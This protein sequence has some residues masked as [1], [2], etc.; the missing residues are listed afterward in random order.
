MEDNMSKYTPIRWGMMISAIVIAWQSLLIP[1]HANDARS[2]EVRLRT[3]NPTVEVAY[4]D[5]TG[6]ASFVFAPEGIDLVD[7]RRAN[8]TPAFAAQ[9]FMRQYGG[10]F[11]LSTPAEDLVILNET[12]SIDGD[13]HVRFQQ[14]Y[15]NIPV[16]GAEIAFNMSNARAIRSINGELIP[17]ISINT[18][19]TIN[20]EQAIDIARQ[21]VSTEYLIDA[22]NIPLSNASLAIFDQ[23]IMG[24]YGPATP[25]LTWRVQLT[26]RHHTKPFDAYVF[27]HAQTGKIITQ[28]NQIAHALSQRICDN[29]N[30]LD[31]DDNSR[32]NCDDDTDALRLNESTPSGVADVDEAWEYTKATYDY[33]YTKFGRDGIDNAGMPMI[34]IVRYCMQS[35]PSYC[36]YPNAY[37]DGEVMT[38][39]EGFSS[40][41]DVIAHEITHGIT[42][43]TARLFYYFQSGAIN[44]A[45]SDIFG[46]F[47]D[48]YHLG[49]STDTAAVR[50]QLGEDLPAYIGAIRN[51]ANPPAFSNPDRMNSRFYDSGFSPGYEWPWDN[52]GV[53]TNSGVANKSAAL[54]VTGGR[55]NNQIITGLGLARTEQLWYRVLTT[56]L[57]SASDYADLANALIY[58][59][60]D[61]ATRNIA[62]MTTT[63]CANVEKVILA[64]E[65]RLSPTAAPANHAPLCPAGT[66]VTN[67]FY[68][69]MEA[70]TTKWSTTGPTWYAY[71]YATSGRYSA[72]AYADYAERR[73][74]RLTQRTSIVIPANAYLHFN[75]AYEFTSRNLSNGLVDKFYHGSIVEYSINNGST[76]QNL[77]PLFVNQG[78]NG[79]ILANINNPIKGQRAFVGVSKGY[80]SS[81]ASLATLSGKRIMLR[82]RYLTDGS[83]ETWYGW[84]IDD[85]RIYT[86][87]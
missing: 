50:W 27:V 14:H 66:R 10:M 6:L 1:A 43:R 62:S 19:P 18:T 17:R 20:Q 11:G 76:W 75:H 55:F 81:R 15:R 8:S 30:A 3:D 52:G 61:M 47:V 65:M 54:M 84:W 41:D 74:L 85:I 35:A 23:R 21:S 57:V 79:T 40:A 83:T 86:C 29:N 58:T 70:F 13:T 59:C 24:G 4:H 31:S 16:V 33:F 5:K 69:N 2:V 44:E 60:K 34:S 7:A 67:T 28:F 51:L 12:T 32:T 25:T 64:T 36:P 48:I 49:S 80:I 9:Q 45:I 77:G 42:E 53:H 26:N 72:Y 71:N 46:E 82:F 56:R 63:H 73:D 78:Y 22:T 68:D 39:G 87:R 38:Y 37:W